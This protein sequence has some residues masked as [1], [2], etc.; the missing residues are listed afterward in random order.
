VVRDLRET[1]SASSR[2]GARMR[3]WAPDDSASM[4]CAIGMPKAEVLP[5]PV[6]DW[7]MMSRPSLIGP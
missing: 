1:C 7:T 6:R 4:R 3:A 5:E 2:V